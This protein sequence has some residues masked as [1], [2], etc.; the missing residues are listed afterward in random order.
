[1]DSTLFCI[2]GSEHQIENVKNDIAKLAARF[3][4]KEAKIIAAK[5]IYD[6]AVYYVTNVNVYDFDIF[7]GIDENIKALEGAVCATVNAKS[8]KITCVPEFDFEDNDS[9]Q[10]FGYWFKGHAITKI[11]PQE[12]I[13]EIFGV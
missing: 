1:M 5:E 12:E 9:I 6:G 4:N 2:E 7:D 10:W 11:S 8:C 13:S 3:S